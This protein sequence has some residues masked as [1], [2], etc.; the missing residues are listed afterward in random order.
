M[1]A[2]RQALT[3]SA[4][5]DL[6]PEKIASALSLVSNTVSEIRRVIFDL[7]P[8]VLD[9]L[10]L[11][12]ALKRLIETNYPH[13]QPLSLEGRGERLTAEDNGNR[14]SASLAVNDALACSLQVEGTPQRLSAAQ[15]LALYRIAQEALNNVRQ[16]A[17]A[18]QARITLQFDHDAT[19]LMV[20]DDGHGIAR[21][22]FRD[23][24][25]LG[26]V[27]MR[28]RAQSVGGCFELTSEPALGTRIVVTVPRQPVTAVAPSH[29]E[30]VEGPRPEPAPDPS[31]GLSKDVE[32]RNGGGGGDSL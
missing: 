29:P 18:R 5:G 11:V 3:G 6:A 1:Q 8:T 21:Q 10:G 20:S 24:D 12:P 25:Q 14:P 27:G 28:E 23:A 30:P 22:E 16:H 4:A 7:H 31:R 2:A 13:P 17:Q 9:E 26:L 32:G 15:E 19:T